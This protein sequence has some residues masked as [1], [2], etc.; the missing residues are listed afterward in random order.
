MFWLLNIYLTGRTQEKHI[1]T[2]KMTFRTSL[3]ILSVLLRPN[4][5]KIGTGKIVQAKF[6]ETKKESRETHMSD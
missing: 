1:L 6:S 3:L 4:H 5:L 2:N